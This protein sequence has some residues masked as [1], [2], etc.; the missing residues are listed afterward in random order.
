MTIKNFLSLEWKSF[1]RSASFKTNL[2][3]KILMVFGALYFIVMFSLLGAG[4]YFLLEEAG[5]PPFETI[6]KFLI[7]YFVFDLVFRFF[8][9][10]TPVMN[11]RPLLYINIKRKNIVNFTLGK[12][13][14][15]FF[16]FMHLFFFIPF[17]IVL[18]IKNFDPI[19]VISWF[20]GMILLIL[21]NNFLTILIDKKDAVFYSVAGIFIAL[22][23]LQYYQI[24]DITLYTQPLFKAI[25]DYP[26]LV[27]IPMLLLVGMYFITFN[28][29]KKN[30]YLDAGLSVKQE[31]AK[32]EE[33]TWLNQFGTLGTFLKNDIKLIKRNKRSKTTV[34]MSFLFLFYGFFFFTGSVEIYD[35]PIWRIFAGIFISGGFLFSFGQFVPSWDSSYYPLMMSQNIQYK[36]YLSAKWWLIVIATVV[37]TFLSAFYLYF[38]WEVYLAIIVGAIYNIGVNAHIVLW[39]GAYIKTP[40]DLNSA[41]NAFGDKKAFN[42]KTLLLTIPKLVLP[43]VLYAIG[44]YTFG[45]IAGYLI[46]AL[47]GIIGF[48]FKNKVFGIIEN[49]YKTEKYK[50]IAAYKQNN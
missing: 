3:L 42:V 4:S 34:L 8:L 19:S 45:P 6:C 43:L 22:G 32:T 49:V 14:L 12:T 11:I 13:V 44:H 1:F 36:E 23:I 2:A 20:I 35:G 10:K 47:S 28:F 21:V 17:S 41:K 33:L 18:L 7:Y 48:A 16:N 15:S 26:F 40:I 24:F 5:M 27:L 29:F 25:F 50:T 46:V 39:A 31:I 30:L 37:S 9:Q 38:G